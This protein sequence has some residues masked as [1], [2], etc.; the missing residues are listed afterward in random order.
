MA[1]KTGGKIY[2][3]GNVYDLGEMKKGESFK[4]KKSTYQFDGRKI[5]VLS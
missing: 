2:Y 1:Q 4:I 3:N 5:V